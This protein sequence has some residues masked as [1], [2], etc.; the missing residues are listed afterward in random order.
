[1]RQVE[2]SGIAVTEK[3]KTL[4]MH[5]CP[6]KR[7]AASV[8]AAA[9]LL[10]AGCSSDI[11]NPV[12]DQSQTS[13]DSTADESVSSPSTDD[14][15]EANN[16][17]YSLSLSN[18]SV[19]LMEGNSVTITVEV[20]RSA[21]YDRQVTLAL[22]GQ[23]PGATNELDWEFSNT[24]L[25]ANQSSADVTL[26]LDYRALPIQRETRTLRVLGT[27]GSAQ[28][29]AIININIEPTNLPDVYLL[30][31][32]SNMVGSSE[33]NAKQALAGGLD[34]PNE[35]IRQLNV[36][37]NDAENFSE[38]FTD[39]FTDVNSIAVPSPRLSI[40]VDPLHNGFDS[41]I[42]GKELT[43]IGLGLSFAKSAL[44][45]TQASAIYLVPA[46][47]SDTGFCRRDRPEFEGILGWNATPNSNPA[48][49]GTF[50]HDRAIARANLAL[51][52]TNGI[53]RGI[54]WHQGEADSDN[55]VCAQQYRQNIRAMVN[56]FRSSIQLDARGSSARGVD[57][58]LP[59]VVGTM[60]KG[61][62]YGNFSATKTIVDTVHREIADVVPF[63][64]HVNNDD[65]IP[66]E[67][68]CG[69]FDCIHFGSAAYREMGSR[70]HFFL[71]QA[72][73]GS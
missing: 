50:L 40:A 70:Y 53:L 37:G 15:A 13:V 19:N 21:G 43:Q 62:S 6:S 65:L 52:E 5:S 64:A 69:L 29:V 8:F 9:I 1:M 16:G 33:N 31:G 14:T 25:Q 51:N 26:S 7:I 63:S 34:E 39:T 20:Q 67:Y 71:T 41:L 32:Q 68:P 44:P 49:S 27:D 4:N 12:L 45:N 66:P 2:P 73:N 56:S 46:A 17:T 59:F 47:W 10:M 57:G 55:A 36:T 18:A 58:N 23:S 61:G 35:R 48:F 11:E 38:I 3:T 30:V 24:R 42:N 22:E 54:L 60:S 28:S 72:A